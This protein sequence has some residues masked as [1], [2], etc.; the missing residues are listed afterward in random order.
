MGQRYASRT[1]YSRR[2]RRQTNFKTSRNVGKR[3]DLSNDLQ[4]VR[5]VFTKL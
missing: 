3:R 4:R 2:E 1:C 5:D